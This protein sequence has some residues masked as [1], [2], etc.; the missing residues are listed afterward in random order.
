[1]SVVHAELQQANA[2]WEALDMLHCRMDC[3]IKSGNDEGKN[4]RKGFGGE[5]P[6]DARLFCR[7][8]GHGRACK[9][10]A[11]IYRRSTA[12]LVPRSLSSLGFCF[13]GRGLSVEWALPT[14]AYPSPAKSS[15]PS[16]SV[17]GLMPNA[18]RERVA[19]PRAGA[20][21][22]PDLRPAGRSPSDWVRSE[23][24]N[25]IGDD[26][27]YIGDITFPSLPVWKFANASC[28]ASC[29]ASTSLSQSKLRRGW[30]GQARP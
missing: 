14:P 25:V 15:R 30:P 4:E 5:T 22:A 13:L 27:Q 19:S 6:T 9:R 21:L 2:R 7:G 8:I 23:Q 10:Q 1:M 11:H 29:R 28:P 12:V 17:R 24:C 16:R 20:A 18:A 3:R 26:S